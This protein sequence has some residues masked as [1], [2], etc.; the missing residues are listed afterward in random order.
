MKLSVPEGTYDMIVANNGWGGSQEITILRGQT[1]TVDLGEMKGKGPA[2]GKVQFV[3]DVEGA[4]LLIDGEKVDYEDPISLT[5]GSHSIA[6]YASDYDVWKRNLYVNSA[7]STVVISLKDEDTDS[8]TTAETSTSQADSSD[9]SSTQSST[10]SDT[11]SESEARQE[12]LD[13][14]KDLITSLTSASSIL[15]D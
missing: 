7:N 3:V 5:Y 6:V 13:T 2:S 8:D 4:V 12:E 9:S 11:Q 15:S 14:L 10:E 1:T